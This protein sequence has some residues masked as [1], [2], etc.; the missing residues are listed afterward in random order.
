MSELISEGVSWHV[1]GISETGHGRFL[2]FVTFRYRGY[3][4]T[5]RRDFPQDDFSDMILAL[6]DAAPLGGS[7]R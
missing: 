5:E 6:R 2:R 1:V 4:P 7:F 3:T